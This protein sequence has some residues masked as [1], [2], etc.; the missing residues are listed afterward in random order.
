MD[1]GV[2]TGRNLARIPVI[3]S[4]IVKVFLSSTF[5]GIYFSFQS[6]QSLLAL[7]NVLINLKF[8]DYTSERNYLFENVVP[9]LREQLIK[10]FGVDFIVRR[11]FIL[12]SLAALN[13][14]LNF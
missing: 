12:F 1:F 10:Q 2:Y 13:T 3:Q 7:L 11:T 14:L 6:N 4:T 5:D 9:H 8:E